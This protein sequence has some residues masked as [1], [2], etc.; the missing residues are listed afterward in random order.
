MQNFNRAKICHALSILL[1]LGFII[2]TI[3]D[4]S[5]YQSTL[6]SA[7]FYIWIIANMIYFIVPAIIL[8]L[9]SIV[10]KRKQTKQRQIA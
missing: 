7:P 6:N 8:L 4:Y 2:K 5:Q 10:I 3:V 1:F 9:V